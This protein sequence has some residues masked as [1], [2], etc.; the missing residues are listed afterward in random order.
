IVY[1]LIVSGNRDARQVACHGGALPYMLQHGFIGNL[2]ENFTGKTGGGVTGGDHAQDFT[3]HTRSYHKIAM[4]SS[5]KK[6]WEAVM[7]LRSHRKLMLFGGVWI[8]LAFAPAAADNKAA[9]RA[10][11]DPKVA[12]EPRAKPAASAPANPRSNIRV[13]TTLVLIPVTVTDP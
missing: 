1:A 3:Q 9:D 7:R 11:T 4:L 13:D 6:G 5:K 12:I 10:A 2:R 8:L